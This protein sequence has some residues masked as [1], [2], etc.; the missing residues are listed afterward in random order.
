MNLIEAAFEGGHRLQRRDE[1]IFAAFTYGRKLNYKDL[2][3]PNYVRKLKRSMKLKQKKADIP[4]IK[5]LKQLQLKF[6]DKYLGSCSDVATSPNNNNSSKRMSPKKAAY[7]KPSLQ[8][9]NEHISEKADS[10]TSD[11]NVVNSHTN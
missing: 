10:Q 4:D 1:N 7:K 11:G 8:A 2:D 5:M 3:D 9:I 6:A